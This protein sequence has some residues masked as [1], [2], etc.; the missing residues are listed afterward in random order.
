MSYDYENIKKMNYESLHALLTSNAIAS[1]DLAEL[2]KRMRVEKDHAIKL[3]INDILTAYFTALNQFI[4]HENSDALLADDPVKV[5]QLCAFYKGENNSLGQVILHRLKK[6]KSSEYER[7]IKAIGRVELVADKLTQSG[8]AKKVSPYYVSATAAQIKLQQYHDRLMKRDP[9]DPTAKRVMELIE[10]LGNV[11]VNA[12]A[13]Q[14]KKIIDE[15]KD[16]GVLSRHH[17]TLIG[18]LKTITG[19]DP[20]A[21]RILHRL[22]ARVSAQEAFQAL[23]EATRKKRFQDMGEKLREMEQGT[24]SEMRVRQA[25]PSL[26]LD[27]SDETDLATKVEPEAVEKKKSKMQ[28]FISN[29]LGALKQAMQ[30]KKQKKLVDIVFEAGAATPSATDLFKQMSTVGNPQLQEFKTVALHLNAELN[31]ISHVLAMSNAPENSPKEVT[32][33]FLPLMNS[34]QEAL[35]KY[36]NTKAGVSISKIPAS[37]HEVYFNFIDSLSKKISNGM[38]NIDAIYTKCNSQLNAEIKQQ[39][40]GLADIFTLQDKLSDRNKIKLFLDNIAKGKDIEQVKLEVPLW[41]YNDPDLIPQDFHGLVNN[42][43][44]LI[45]LAEIKALT[46]QLKAELPDDIKLRPRV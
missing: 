40:S 5:K 22:E 2:I 3:K 7:I 14:V 44:A 23:P 38:Y 9:T 20:A 46:K 25:M 39:L 21:I 42:L 26:M 8:A 12:S 29:P 27:D 24:A 19:R 35:V 1:E 43:K 4:L 31:K 16:D 17:A 15:F 11:P 6:R 10:R 28:T 37:S 45:Q 32:N 13:N 33:Q 36:H 30:N 18:K 41:I 34:V